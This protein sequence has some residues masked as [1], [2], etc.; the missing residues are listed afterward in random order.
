MLALVNHRSEVLCSL[1]N[2]VEYFPA[3]VEGSW[4]VGV[5]DVGEA[6]GF[7]L[8]APG[9]VDLDDSIQRK[10]FEPIEGLVSAHRLKDG[11]VGAIEEEAAIGSFNDSS[12]IL[13]EV[14]WTD[15]GGGG[16]VFR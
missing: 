8:F 2:V 1:L 3:R 11:E 16:W 4:R 14:K 6:V 7:A 10:V 12:V 15:E 9:D 5:V 13:K